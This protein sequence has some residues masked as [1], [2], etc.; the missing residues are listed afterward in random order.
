MGEASRKV[1]ALSLEAERVTTG[2]TTQQCLQ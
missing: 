2:Q 1:G